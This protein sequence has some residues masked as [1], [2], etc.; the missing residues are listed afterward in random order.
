MPVI[1]PF[2]DTELD[3][4]VFAAEAR[5]AAA[6]RRAFGAATEKLF[7]T[8]RAMTAAGVEPWVSVDDSAV[9]ATVWQDEVPEL[10]LHVQAVYVAAGGAVQAALTTGALPLGS[11]SALNQYAADYLAQTRNRLV[12]FGDA[13][14][15]DI[16]G[17]LLEGF[18]AGEGIEPLT[19]RLRGVADMS[20][21]R[22]RTIARTEV[23][24]S[25]NAGADVGI[26]TLPVAL[27]PQTK[28][29]LSAAD[30]RTR[31]SHAEANG[32]VV[33]FNEPFSV[34]GTA[35]MYPGEWGA[36]AAEVISCRC[37]CTY[38]D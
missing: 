25:S 7:R 3:A 16:R 4:L 33:P 5:F 28:R 38:G 36:P 26:R 13:A 11:A 21:R 34:G 2:P 29:W 9:A 30:S 10:A 23:V 19:R 14:W 1:K 8:A 35:M 27:Q 12:R 15:S 22:A 6:V 24:S 17:Q 20:Q 18:T 31:P 32:Q 37:T